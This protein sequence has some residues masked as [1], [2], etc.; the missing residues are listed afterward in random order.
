MKQTALASTEWAIKTKV[1]HR[2]RFHAE[3]DAIALW[4]R[5]LAAI[6]AI[7]STTTGELLQRLSS[8]AHAIPFGDD[9]LEFLAADALI[10][11]LYAATLPQVANHGFE[12]YAGRVLSLLERG[13]VLALRR[14]QPG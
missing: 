3:M 6:V 14:V 7:R 8:D 10:E 11:R 4:P 9:R 13:K 5:V 12:R 1:T 2:T